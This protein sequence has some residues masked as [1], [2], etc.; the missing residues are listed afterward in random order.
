MWQTPSLWRTHTTT[1]LEGDDIMLKVKLS[2]VNTFV[3]NLYEQ[4]D[5]KDLTASAAN[6]IRFWFL[7]NMT[8]IGRYS[9]RDFE[10]FGRLNGSSGG[11]S[12]KQ[13]RQDG[14]VSVTEEVTEIDHITYGTGILYIHGE[15]QIPTRDVTIKNGC[16]R[17]CDADGVEQIYDEEPNSS[18]GSFKAIRGSHEL[19]VLEEGEFYDP[20]DLPDP[21]GVTWEFIKRTSKRKDGMIPYRDIIKS[22]SGVDTPT[23]ITKYGETPE[24]SVT[25]PQ[26]YS[27]VTATFNDSTVYDK[28]N[29]RHHF[30]LIIINSAQTKS[31]D[32]ML[33]QTFNNEN[34][35][36]DGRLPRITSRRG[37]FEVKNDMQVSATSKQ[38]ILDYI[39]P[40]T[41]DAYDE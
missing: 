12:R 31:I 6:A 9:N 24:Y 19:P 3:S 17:N 7:S 4:V 2:E 22:V 10:R 5:V 29:E 25:R 16:F 32:T 38:R 34:G 36:Y 21:T 27:G 20:D 13:G 11:A 39:S 14:W 18:T 40:L 35:M 30:P 28:A 15:M 23:S 41:N 8:N 33:D 26:A 1:R 37:N